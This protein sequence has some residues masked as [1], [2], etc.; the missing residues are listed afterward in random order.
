M[1][2]IRTVFLTVALLVPIASGWAFPWD[3]DMVDQPS[4]K[5]QES[6]A[7][8]GPP[9]SVPISGGETVPLPL[10]DIESL[11]MKDAAI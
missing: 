9:G 6:A 7:P 4:E 8:P 3:K 10:S 11:E 5:A 2:R 1:M